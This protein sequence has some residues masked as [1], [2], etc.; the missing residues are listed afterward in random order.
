[1][2]LTL[3]PSRRVVDVV[4]G[5]TILEAL[6]RANEPISYSCTDG[7]CG[8]C[9]CYA[10]VPTAMP[11]GEHAVDAVDAVPALRECLACQTI[12]RSDTLVELPDADEPVVLPARSA[13]AV[14]RSIEFMAPQIVRLRLEADRPIE[15]LAGQH[16]ELAF[17][18]K[19]RRFYSTSAAGDGQAMVF[20]IQ[21]H[22]YGLVSQYVASSLRVGEAV[23]VRGP[24]G[25]SYLR[26]KDASNLI[27]VSSGT[28]LGAL[29]SLLAQIAAARMPNAVYVYA[30]FGFSEHVYC[31][32]ELARYAAALPGL[33][34]CD[35]IIASGPVQRGER[36]GLLTDA[37]SKDLG[38]LQRSTAYLFGSPSAIEGATRRLLGKGIDP[39]RLHAVPYHVTE[40]NLPLR[41]VG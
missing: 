3:V 30:G 16:F 8:L 4:E 2:R 35:V 12:P 37:L 1:M 5:E 36:R 34:R 40:V 26:R 14:V 21:I 13:K 19:A 9:L 7:R 24:L 17:A 22:P 25:R 27:L 38:E 15:Y 23:R 31:R 32:E 11:D 33:R 18:C 20:D 6:R 29:T 28:G 41:I 39:R 10:A